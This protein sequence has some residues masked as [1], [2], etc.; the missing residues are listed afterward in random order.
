[1]KPNLKKGNCVDVTNLEVV[2]P[3]QAFGDGWQLSAIRY[4]EGG[5]G[6]EG[7][8]TLEG[9]SKSNF[10]QNVEHVKREWGWTKKK[11]VKSIIERN[12]IERNLAF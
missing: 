10:K 3:I 4:R 12:E 9:A 1:M 5:A 8:A 11:S 2:V 7:K 6:Y